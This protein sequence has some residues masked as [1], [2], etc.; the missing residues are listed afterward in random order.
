MI[1]VSL[2]PAGAD[3]GLFAGGVSVS[4][5]HMSSTYEP[6]GGATHVSFYF[7]RLASCR[8]KSAQGPGQVRPTRTLSSKYTGTFQLCFIF[9]LKNVMFVTHI[10]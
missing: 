1:W 2:T 9:M 4:R 10:C 5:S 3:L 7:Y 6:G 8:G